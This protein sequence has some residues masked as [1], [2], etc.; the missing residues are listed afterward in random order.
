MQN[1]HFRRNTIARLY[2]FHSAGLTLKKNLLE[3][4]GFQNNSAKLAR[5]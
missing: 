4:K 5:I 2:A 1:N 3:L